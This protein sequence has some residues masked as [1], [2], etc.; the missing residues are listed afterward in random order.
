[1]S[2]RKLPNWLTEVSKPARYTGG[3]LNAVQKDSTRMDLRFALA[4]PDVYE[5][6]M[7]HLGI[8]IL[9]EILN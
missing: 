1:M 6:A 5:I 9:Y 3:E 2:G 8:K 4:F 7:S